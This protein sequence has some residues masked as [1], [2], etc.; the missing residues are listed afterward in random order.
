MSMIDMKKGVLLPLLLLISVTLLAQST[1]GSTYNIFGVGTL[2][3]DGLGAYRS[4]NNTG[5]GSRQPQSV[6]LKNPAAL[7]A[8]SGPTQVFD[9]DVTL[10]ALSQQNDDE[11]FNTMLGGLENINLWLKAGKRAGLVLGASPFS[12]GR[13][14]ITDSYVASPIVGSYSIRYQ[15]DGGIT[16]FYVGGSQGIG[17]FLSVGAKA[18]FLLGKLTSTQTLGG[19]SLVSGVVSTDERVLKKFIFDLGTQVNIPVAENQQLTIGVTYRPRCD[20]KFDTESKLIR[21]GY[22]SVTTGTYDN[23]LIFPEKYGVGLEY[24]FRKLSF[25]L[26]GEYDRW[27]INGQYDD[28]TYKDRISLSF[29]MTY[30]KDPAS[31][32]YLG[33]VTWRAGYGFRTSYVEVNKTTFANSSVSLGMGLPISQGFGMVNIGYKYSGQGTSS[34]NLVYEQLHTFSLNI[35]IRDLWF[36]KIRYD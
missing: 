5:I 20:L 28:Y 31:Y 13:Y 23:K 27:G 18:S 33:R 4:M 7:N 2:S 3:E 9:V 15:G 11:S 35:S 17:K 24:R 19:N 12:D 22:D 1:T 14:D 10:K 25:A 36:R 6:N 34:N 26:D 32:N 30:Q 29:G 16:R 8:I 21:D